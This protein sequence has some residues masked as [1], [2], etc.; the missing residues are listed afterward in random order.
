[1]LGTAHLDGDGAA[2]ILAGCRAFDVRAGEPHFRASFSGA[3][4]LAVEEGF[5]VL[6][7]SPLGLARSVVTCEALACA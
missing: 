4:L 3:E 1:M 7:S 6:R 2:E 5:V